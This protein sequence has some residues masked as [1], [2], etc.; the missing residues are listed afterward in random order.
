MEL[1]VKE[2]LRRHTFR[3]LEE[4]HGVCARP[5]ATGDKFALN[6]DQILTKSG[7]PVAEQCRGLVIRPVETDW[8]D[9]MQSFTD[10]DWKDIR[11]GEI[12]VLAWPMCRFYNH[13]D[14]NASNID[15]SHPSL[16]VYEK[17]DGTCIILYWDPLHDKWHAG[18]RSVPEADL[19]INAGNMDIGDETFSQLFL[20]ALKLTREDLSGKPVDWVIDGPDKIIHLNKEMT[21]VFELVSPYNQIVVSYP[22]PRVYLLAARH[23]QTGREV[24]IETLRIEHVRR[25]RTWEIRDVYALAA[26]VDMANPMEL[27]GSVVCVQD[28][29]SFQR[30]KVKNK[31][32]VLAHKSKD[33]L[34]ASP[35]NM[36]EAIIRETV[37]DILPL[38]PTDDLRAK[39]IAMKEA[40]AQ[41]CV[42]V[43]ERCA[44]FRAD[45][46]GNRRR[47]AEQVML[48]GDW[49]AVYFNLWENRAGNARE[50]FKTTCEKSKLS[51]SSLDGILAKLTL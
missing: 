25:P 14:P 2:Y 43:D 4:E 6:Y 46:N 20:R 38:L 41:Y 45:A 3:E 31:S 33:I 26:F 42:K 36:L 16:K 51:D 18:T 9:M 19:P 10:R 44:T 7:D 5:N 32:Y 21:Y 22:E 24:P 34:T 35:R 47:F 8:F 48:S 15:W 37:D 50:W 39:V 49:T 23:T 11:V 30:L 27:E 40:Y 28:G 1:L 29:D 12:E 13:G 17:V